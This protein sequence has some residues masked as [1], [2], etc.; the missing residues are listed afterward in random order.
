M[1]D[2]KSTG[3]AGKTTIGPKDRLSRLPAELLREIYELVWTGGN[4]PA[5]PLSR[6]L[7]PF[8]REQRFKHA[9]VESVECFPAFLEVL[10]QPELCRS[11]RKLSGVG[12]YHR[13]REL[14]E[15]DVERVFEKLVRLEHLEIFINNSLGMKCL[16]SA[17]TFN[18]SPAFSV[19]ITPPEDW[20]TC[21]LKEAHSPSHYQPRRPAQLHRPF[22]PGG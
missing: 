20:V 11:I 6:T 18:P 2:E 22:P 8:D 12:A 4:P 5:A 19:T 13:S 10:E 21:D 1:D 14:P 3:R 16:L 9:D 17:A 15:K 7:R